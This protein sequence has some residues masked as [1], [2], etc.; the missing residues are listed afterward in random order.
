MST[1][2]SKPVNPV[3][4]ISWPM[5]GGY[6]GSPEVRAQME[7]DQPALLATMNDAAAEFASGLP[8]EGEVRVFIEGIDEAGVGTVEAIL[9]N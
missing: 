7:R 8:G 4:L 5:A 2:P 1:D 9:R 3:F 6:F